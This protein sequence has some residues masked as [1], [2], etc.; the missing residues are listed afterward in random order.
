MKNRCYDDFVLLMFIIFNFV[1]YLLFCYNILL[2]CNFD[3]NV[4]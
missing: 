1:D 3:R 2:G 4:E